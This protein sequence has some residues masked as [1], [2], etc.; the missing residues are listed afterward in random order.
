MGVVALSWQDNVPVGARVQQ[1]TPA[2]G[3]GCAP[4]IRDRRR[5]DLDPPCRDVV[6]ERRG[7]LGGEHGRCGLVGLR[8]VGNPDVGRE[9]VGLAGDGA[10]R[11]VR[12]WLGPTTELVLTSNTPVG[13]TPEQLSVGAADPDAMS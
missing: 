13:T 6:V 11:M 10:E 9:V 2:G 1:T 5:R 8:V 7:A 12:H 3:V 4:N